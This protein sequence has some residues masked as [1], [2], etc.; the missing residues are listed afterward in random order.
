MEKE[1]YVING[2]FFVE[3]GPLLMCEL[4]SYLSISDKEHIEK[5][6]SFCEAHNVV[7]EDS[8]LILSFYTTGDVDRDKVLLFM[9]VFDDISFK[10]SFYCDEEGHPIDALLLRGIINL[11][12]NH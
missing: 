7:K 5:L 8:K 3:E 9:Y 4:L 6:Y 10:Q 1:V 2:K 12:F 11:D